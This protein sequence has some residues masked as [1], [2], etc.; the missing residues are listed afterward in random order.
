MSFKQWF[1]N[2]VLPTTD[3]IMSSFTKAISALESRADVSSEL[4]QDLRIDAE[5]AQ[6]EADRATLLAIK[7]KSAFTI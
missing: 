7:L 3:G 6:E 2:R 5:L 1:F 4:A